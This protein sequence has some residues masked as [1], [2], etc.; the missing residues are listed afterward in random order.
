MKVHLS[1]NSDISDV[2]MKLFLNE[3]KL[4][5]PIHFCLKPCQQNAH[6]LHEPTCQRIKKTKK[7][8]YVQTSSAEWVLLTASHYLRMTELVQE[9]GPVCVCV[10]AS[11]C[12]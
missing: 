3:A 7:L 6:S 8:I 2:H 12:V 9:S 11:V 10:S 1:D 4:M 5:H